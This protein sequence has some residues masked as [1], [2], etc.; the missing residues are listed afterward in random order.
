MPFDARKVALEALNILD[1]GHL[2]LDAVMED[3]ANDFSSTP[4]RERA[5]LQAL[6]YGVLRW[7]GRLD[8]IVSRFSRSPL[9]KIDPKVLNI[10]RLGLFQIIYLD[11]IP[12][13]AAVNTAVNMVKA[14]GATWAAGFVNA[15][16]RRTIREYPSVVFPDIKHD[17]L[18]A[19]SVNHSFPRWIIKKWH[20]RY[21]LK[22]TARLCDA[23]NAIAPITVRTNRLK[24]TP[25]E[26]MKSLTAETQQVAQTSYCRDGVTFY[27]PAVP[28]AQLQS[29]KAGWFQV[30]D[31][32]AQLVS[33]LL[34]PK[35]G[36]MV[37]DACA[38]LGGK[39][40]HI[41][42]LMKNKGVLIALD[43]DGAK[44]KRL[45]AEMQRL[46]VSIVSTLTHDL[47]NSNEG[48]EP[49]TFDRVLLDAPCSGLGVMR[50]HPDIKWRASKRTPLPF[51]QR[52]MK[53][54]KNASR[55]V[56]PGGILVYAVCSPEPEEN[57]A[58]INDFLKNYKQFDIDNK[59]GKLPERVCAQA[60]SEGCLR[61][62][63]DLTQMDGFFAVRLKR[64]S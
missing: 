58:V 10:L 14:S 28:I 29:F 32:A 44:L 34:N 21:G 46:A 4:R 59:C 50:R 36:E 13:S 42:Q 53:L 2:T 48:P 47:E 25:P 5:L 22:K 56:K 27:N 61:T 51:K 15:L 39:T 31:E 18:A 52:Q 64:G 62:Y 45:E 12:D 23:I 3:V 1:S 6:V 49:N 16:L 41:A 63:P 20:Q 8:Y 9:D 30:Q 60:V 37:L 19:L 55:L 43:L 57:E 54:L 33:L 35:P 26:L 40:G 7:K 24:T 11:R 38:G 17:A